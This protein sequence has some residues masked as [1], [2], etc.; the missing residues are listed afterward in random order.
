M[1]TDLRVLKTESFFPYEKSRTLS[2]LRGEVLD[3]EAMHRAW[4]AFVSLLCFLVTSHAGATEPAGRRPNVL[5]ILLDNVGKDWFRCYGSQEDLTPVM[6]HLACTGLKFRNFYVTPVCS[7][8]R[9]MKSAG[10]DTCISGNWQ[11]HDVFDA[12][13]VLPTPAELA[14]MKLPWEF[15]S[16]SAR[17]IRAEEEKR[18]KQRQHNKTNG[19]GR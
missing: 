13:D 17:K 12:S 10:Y 14:G 1:P 9:V 19:N 7:T 3:C 6:D 4:F 5:F 11:I 18:K 2:K 16:I 8:T 15:R